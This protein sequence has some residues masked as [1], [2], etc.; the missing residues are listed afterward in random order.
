MGIIIAVLLVAVAVVAMVAYG[1]TPHGGPTTLC[2]PI[3]VFGYRINSVTGDCRYISI[4]ELAIAG[5]F[6][7]LAL[8]V[9]LASRPHRQA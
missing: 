2:G 7:F 3:D 4:G 5:V 9:A 6:L 8:M 1:G